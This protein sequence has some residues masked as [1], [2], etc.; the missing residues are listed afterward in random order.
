MLIKILASS[1]NRIDVMQATG[2]YPI[3]P[4]VTKIGGLDCAGVIVNPQT[5]E[6]VDGEIVMSLL[7][8]G[9]Y[10]RYAVAHKDHV[11]KA[12]KNFDAE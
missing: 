1:V 8:G 6:P 11:L 10:S 7:S 9:A 3:P 2:K 4:G 12:P 5:L